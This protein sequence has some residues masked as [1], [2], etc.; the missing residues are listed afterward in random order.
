MWNFM[1]TA[2]PA[3]SPSPELARTAPAPSAPRAA[4]TVCCQST[5]GKGVTVLGE[6]TGSES[7]YI[8]GILEGSIDLPENRVTIGPN[9]QVTASIVARDVVVLGKVC[10]SV[11]ASNLL[12]IRAEGSLTGDVSVAR[13]SMADGAFFQGAV[14]IHNTE[15]K[16]GLL[17]ESPRIEA[18]ASKPVRAAHPEAAKIR[19]EPFAQSA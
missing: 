10:G 5:I 4:S 2:T 15:A 7:L 13:L 14:D 8:D 16:L 18:V 12:D 11:A 6:I 9:G 17:Y 19:M 3:A 1:Q